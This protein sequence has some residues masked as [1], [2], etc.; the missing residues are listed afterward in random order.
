MQVFF[1]S[2]LASYT[3]LLKIHFITR[4]VHKPLK[5][6]PYEPEVQIHKQFW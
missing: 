2:V 3:K 5:P 6:I 4:G 1:Y